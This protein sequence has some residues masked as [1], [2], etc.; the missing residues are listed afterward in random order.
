M[1][2]IIMIECILRNHFGQS[3][4]Q[5]H[6]S[7]TNLQ[8]LARFYFSSFPQILLLHALRAELKREHIIILN[9]LKYRFY[10]LLRNWQTLASVSL[11]QKRGVLRDICLCK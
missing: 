11:Q 8:T 2:I 7:M 4:S 5:G 6:W 9:I 3:Q 1:L 10:L